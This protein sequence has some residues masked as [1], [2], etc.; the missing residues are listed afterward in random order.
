MIT[1]AAI[2][3][4]GAANGIRPVDTRRD[5]AGLADLLAIAF[6]ATLDSAGRRMVSSMRRF[7]RAGWPGWLVGH[8]VLPPAAYPQGYVWETDGKLVG[9]ASMMEVT[10]SPRRWVIANVAVHPGSRR[11]GIA[12]A[13]MQACLDEVRN[14]GGREV[15]LQVDSDNAGARQLYEGLGFK[16]MAKRVIWTRDG[17]PLD[18][19]IEAAPMRLRKA[20]EWK[21]QWALA[22]KLY[23]EGAIWPY[24]L[25]PSLFKTASLLDRMGIGVRRHWVWMEAGDLR[26]SLTARWGIDEGRWRLLLMLAPDLH[27]QA[28][29]AVLQFGLQAL[30]QGT[31]PIALDHTEAVGREHFL[32]LRFRP[33]RSLT[34]MHC[35]VQVLK[36][37][38]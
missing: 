30:Q 3:S 13:L 32:K 14:K 26:A 34:W 31:A 11:R 20:D 23:P 18:R 38:S 27:N 1:G 35:P 24:P 22:Q 37:G 9:N 19:K 33:R 15:V 17:V 4:A 10:G 16:A 5:M 28:E 21:A 25:R 6:A 12:T 2:P 7:G 36:E 8:I 29:Q